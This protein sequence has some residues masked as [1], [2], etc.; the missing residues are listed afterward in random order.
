MRALV[1]NADGVQNTR[2]DLLAGAARDRGLSSTV[3]GPTWDTSGCSAALTAV[4]RTGR[5]WVHHDTEEKPT[6]AMEAT[7]AFIVRSAFYGAFGPSPDV[8]LSGVNDGNNTGYAALHSGTV[9]AALTGTARGCRSLAISAEFDT[10]EETTAYVARR[11]VG[12]LLALQ[13]PCVLNVNIPNRPLDDL[14]GIVPATLE[15]GGSVQATVTESGDDF[16]PVTLKDSLEGNDPQS[17][18]KTVG[19]GFVS[20]TAIRPPAEEPLVDL[21]EVL[22]RE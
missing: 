15:P 4:S 17:D 13:R 7:P 12:W 3:V 14:Q 11:A 22:D 5:V 21:E 2:L 6:L 20:V 16:Q 1:T 9:G 8:V 19:R 18:E 10:P